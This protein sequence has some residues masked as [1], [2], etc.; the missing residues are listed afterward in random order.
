MIDSKQRNLPM[1][2]CNYLIVIVFLWMLSYSLKNLLLMYMIVEDKNIT[3]VE[4]GHV[5][6]PVVKVTRPQGRL[7]QFSYSYLLCIKTF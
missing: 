6:A 1:K 5:S 4:T 3:P 7:V 2:V